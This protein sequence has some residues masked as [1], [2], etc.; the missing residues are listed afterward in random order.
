MV[1]LA[2]ASLLRAVE[3]KVTARQK[4]LSAKAASGEHQAEGPPPNPDHQRWLSRHTHAVAFIPFVIVALWV[5]TLPLD[6]NH[7]SP[8]FEDMARSL[9]WIPTFLLL[10]LSVQWLAILFVLAAAINRS[11]IRYILVGRGSEGSN[12]ASRVLKHPLIDGGLLVLG[13][14]LITVT[15]E[16]LGTIGSLSVVVIIVGL[17]LW[18]TDRSASGSRQNLGSAILGGGL[19]AISVFGLQQRSDDRQ[20]VELDRRNLQITLSL[21]RDF[22]GIDLR[23]RD[24]SDFYLVGKVLAEAR[25]DSADLSVTTLR[26]TDLRKAV[27]DSANLKY[28]DLSSANLVRADLRLANM[29]YAQLVGADLRSARFAG[30][31]LCNANLSKSDLR[32]TNLAGADLRGIDLSL[33]KT[34][35]STRWPAGFNPRLEHKYNIANCP[36]AWHGRIQLLD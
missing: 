7:I 9:P 3:R 16:R 28:S 18:A 21:S 5:P 14:T 29:P 36:T 15:Q 19:I 10:L 20:Q 24:L 6:E 25:L 2:L 13:A 1:A 33:A 8:Q 23:N 11:R 17:F 12:S 26:R 34:D 22:T 30:A 31:N 32:G 35:S 4:P 27:M